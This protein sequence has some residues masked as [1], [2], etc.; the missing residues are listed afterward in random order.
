MENEK[1]EIMNQIRNQVNM[2]N[3]FKGLK[4]INNHYQSFSGS[5][6]KAW[7]SN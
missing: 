2:S 1:A 5:K 6:Q 3:I 7:S 4:K